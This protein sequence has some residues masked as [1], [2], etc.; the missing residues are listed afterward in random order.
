MVEEKQLESNAHIVITLESEQKPV[1]KHD[2]VLLTDDKKF[3]MRF[4]AVGA[5]ITHILT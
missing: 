1:L 4:D 2:K 5:G 3:S